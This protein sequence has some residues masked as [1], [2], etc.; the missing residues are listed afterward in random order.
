MARCSR[1]KGQSSKL[2]KRNG[3]RFC[4]DC[5]GEL[6][7]ISSNKVNF[8]QPKEVMEAIARKMQGK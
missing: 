8:I 6:R 3:N 2:I 5:A 4:T 7:Y 1:C